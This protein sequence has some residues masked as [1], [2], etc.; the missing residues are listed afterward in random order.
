ME[1]KIA[2]SDR[3]GKR[4]V[5]A[6]LLSTHRSK[7][8]VTGWRNIKVLSSLMELPT[9]GQTRPF[10]GGFA[11]TPRPLRALWRHDAVWMLCR[12]RVRIC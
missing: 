11:S 7:A 3:K 4:T 6:P 12:H 1:Q 9:I 5:A 8:S 2:S 10:G